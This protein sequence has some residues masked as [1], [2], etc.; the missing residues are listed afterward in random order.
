MHHCN[1]EKG[2]SGSPILLLKSNKVIEVHYGGKTK[3]NF[4]TY[5][6]Y[7]ID[8]IN[9]K[10]KNEINLK[11]ITKEEKQEYIFGEE[12]AKN[13]KNNIELEING[14]KSKLVNRYKLIKGVNK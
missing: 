9:K 4:G 7:A 12:F 5:I 6:K 10:Y 8:E 2:S 3:Y 11:Y 14:E 1:T 13:N